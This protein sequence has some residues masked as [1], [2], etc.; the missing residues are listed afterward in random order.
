M[1]SS[2][3]LPVR[4]A[5]SYD[6]KREVI[7]GSKGSWGDAGWTLIACVDRDHALQVMADFPQARMPCWRRIEAGEC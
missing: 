7:K 4:V 1:Q 2:Y 5:F 3:R 6:R